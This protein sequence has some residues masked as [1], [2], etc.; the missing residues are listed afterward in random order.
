MNKPD[1]LYH[2][3]HNK[4]I[5]EFKPKNESP[6]YEGEPNA[7][8]ATP[9]IEVAAMFLVPKSITTEISKYG[10]TYTVFINGSEQD[11]KA[12]DH[13]GAIYTLSSDGFETDKNIGMGETEWL[14]Q[15]PV[16]PLNKVVYDSALD[17]IH[18]HKV[19]IYFLS[20]DT[21]NRIKANPELGLEIVEKF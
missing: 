15:K 11:F 13:G 4:D 18:E 1:V 9:Y 17:A 20:N 8:F 7:V 5:L 14:S 21:F 3:S 10:S 16:K 19:K 2:A 12:L 6:R